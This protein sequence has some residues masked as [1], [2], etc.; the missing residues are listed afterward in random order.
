MKIEERAGAATAKQ[1]TVEILQ[2]R[3]AITVP[4][5]ALIRAI[6]RGV[7]EVIV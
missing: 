3:L 2:A 7:P 4:E 1:V 5:A 6:E